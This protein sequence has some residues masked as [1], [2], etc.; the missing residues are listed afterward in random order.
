MNANTAK[1]VLRDESPEWV[2]ANAND[3]RWQ[4]LRFG[5]SQLSVSQLRR[6][7]DWLLSGKPIALDTFNYDPERQLW[8]P[9]AIGLQVPEIVAGV[10]A[11]STNERAKALIREVGQSNCSG[12]SLNPFSGVPGAF[13]RSHRSADITAMCRFLLAAAERSEDHSAGARP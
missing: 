6:L 1:Q 7:L 11:P 8:C 12:F 3:A 2:E 13:F 4:A 10:G 9:L 5:L